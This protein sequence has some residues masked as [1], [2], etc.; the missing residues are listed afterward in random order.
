MWI[1]QVSRRECFEVY[2][3]SIKVIEKRVQALKQI[4]LTNENEIL[5]I[6]DIDPHKSFSFPVLVVVGNDDVKSLLSS[7]K[8]SPQ[9]PEPLTAI[10]RVIG[11]IEAR[12][13]FDAESFLTDKSI[14][15]VIAILSL[16]EGTLH[17]DG[18]I[19]LQQLS[20][21][22]CKRTFAYAWG[23]AIGAQVST[24]SFLELPA[25]W[26]EVYSML[27]TPTA[28]S[29]AQRT[30]SHLTSGLTLLTQLAFG[31]K[32]SQPSGQLA[33]SLLRG[34]KDGQERAWQMLTTY[35]SRPLS[36]EA[37]QSMAREDRGLLLQDALRALTNAKGRVEHDT[38]IAACAFLAT[39]LAPGSLDH[40]E[41]LKSLA[42]PELLVWYG[43]YA[44]L[45][46]PKEILSLY[47]GL[48]FR[49]LRDLLRSEDKLAAPMS[50]VSYL[51]LKIMARAGLEG[52]VGMIGHASELQVELIP[53]VSSSFTFQLRN[54]SRD[55]ERQHSFDMEPTNI[56]MSP[57]E[58]ATRLA[59]E[60]SQLAKDLPD[61]PDDY[62]SR[63][64]TRRKSN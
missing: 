10:S 38:L 52:V 45:Q 31:I 6:W 28:L 39:R 13:H 58:R 15:S 37:I 36:I 22:L 61:Y 2:L 51:E 57:R 12:Q 43:L 64:N 34:D 19:G 20:P 63:K 30:V 48:G 8:A 46:H 29:N 14:Y 23:K 5:L 3:G 33:Y 55:D 17:G 54:R 16:V 1:A 49:I 60:L 59:F 50:D 47:S 35:L 62:S 32:P 56:R 7:I 24:D 44:T 53:Y 18:K 21:L 9:V 11:Q 27:N 26:L 4:K 41:T 42:L 40:F 25:R